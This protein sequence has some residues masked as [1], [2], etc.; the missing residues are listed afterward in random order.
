MLLL[1]PALGIVFN[2][3]IYLP[4]F[5]WLW[6]APYGR[7]TRRPD[8]GVAV[9]G[10]GDAIATLRSMRSNPI[11]LNMTLLAGAA[12]LF[13][14]NAYQAQM[15][16]FATDLGHGDA[17]LSYAA[18]A[19]AD[20]AGGLGAAFML[21]SRGLLPPRVP[22][23]LLLGMLWCGALAIFAL[24]HS[25]ALSLAALFCAGFLEL[26]FGA[27]AQALVQLHAPAALRGHVIGV[28]VMAALGLRFISG[29]TVGVL[30][31]IVG[32]HQSLA[33]SAAALFTVIALLL[34]AQRRR[35]RAPPQLAVR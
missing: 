27:M 13:I 7:R 11:L 8:A 16:S 9:R 12:S 24:T 34:V 19:A 23:A 3:A 4:M 31:A 32:V 15:P 20:A 29:F 14:G 18:L 10:L 28:F 21:E 6:K 1:G 30:G 5:L 2:A 25:Y 33:L 17:G 22:T 26:A 35:P